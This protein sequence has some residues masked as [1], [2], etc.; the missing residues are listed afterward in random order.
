MGYASSG[1][2]LER[3]RGVRY[4]E[5]CIPA[6]HNNPASLH[7]AIPNPTTHTINLVMDMNI[8]RLVKKHERDV[9]RILKASRIYPDMVTRYQIYFVTL[10]ALK[11][12][13][14]LGLMSSLGFQ[15]ELM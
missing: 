11:M 15:W 14:G 8:E 13:E 4:A 2:N 10:K 7:T 5:P 3:I 6:P 12:F 9:K 1:M